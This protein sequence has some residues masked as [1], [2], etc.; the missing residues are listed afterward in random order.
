MEAIEGAALRCGYLGGDA[1]FVGRGIVAQRDVLPGANLFLRAV[2]SGLD[3]DIA[4][5]LSATRATDMGLREATDRFRHRSPTGIRLHAAVGSWLYH[6][7]GHRRSGEGTPHPHTAY[8][9]IYILPLLRHEV[10]QQ[11][12]ETPKK[13]KKTCFHHRLNQM[14]SIHFYPETK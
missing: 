14:N 1:V 8:A 11:A 5:F 2:E 13:D 9:R 10:A 6:A 7:K 3:E 4:I 12:T